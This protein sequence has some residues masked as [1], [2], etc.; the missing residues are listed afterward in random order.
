MRPTV[1]I[2]DDDSSVR[3]AL[4][5]LL[6]S[7]GYETKMFSSAEEF[8]TTPH[9]TFAPKCLVLDVK[10]PGLS[11]LDLQGELSS[12]NI[13]IPIVFITGHGDISMSVNAM[14][15]GAVDFLPKPFDDYELLDAI[16]A[17]LQ[18]SARTCKE[19]LELSDLKQRLASLS[20]REYEILTYVLTGM[21][22]KQVAFELNISERT[23]KAHRKQVLL[24][25]GVRSIAEL[26]RLA[27]KLGIK[28]AQPST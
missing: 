20:K 4:E 6:G 19:N 18:K 21:L 10:M 24:K 28:P 15:R 11:G 27:E 1:F 17:A 23:V 26:A 3:N 5:L 16:R 22:N 9:D 12:L 7:A 14:K 25:M 2:V 13:D 8:L